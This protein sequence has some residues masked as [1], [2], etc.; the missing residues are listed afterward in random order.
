MDVRPSLLRQASMPPYS[1]NR[2]TAERTALGPNPVKN[3]SHSTSPPAAA[4]AA[5]RRS[6]VRRKAYSAPDAAEKCR[7]DTTSTC[8]SPAAR[9]ISF[10]SLLSALLSPKAAARATL[11]TCWPNRRVSA[12]HS[13][14]RSCRAAPARPPWRPTTATCC[15]AASRYTPSALRARA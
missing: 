10:S 11:P 14:S 13:S 7:P 15:A 6:F 8:E 5:R 2:A 9:N 3:K 12:L 4:A 1:I